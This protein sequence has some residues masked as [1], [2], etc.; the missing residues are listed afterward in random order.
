MDVITTTP[1]NEFLAM[2]LLYGI[3]VAIIFLLLLI[4]WK[5]VFGRRAPS[6]EG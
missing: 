6:D 2:V 1:M 4:A 3:P 5:R